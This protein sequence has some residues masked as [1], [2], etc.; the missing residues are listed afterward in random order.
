MWK[1]SV[2]L[3]KYTKYLSECLKIFPIGCYISLFT[4]SNVYFIVLGQMIYST[5][6]IRILAHMNQHFKIVGSSSKCK[7]LILGITLNVLKACFSGRSTD[8]RIYQQ[9]I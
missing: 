5:V 7:T 6:G 9:G 4:Q 3:L 1:S 8:L 2:L